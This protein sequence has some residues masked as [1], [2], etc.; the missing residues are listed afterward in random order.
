MTG[1]GIELRQLSAGMGGWKMGG[2]INAIL[3]VG[4]E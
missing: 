3:I 2:M 1:R 4:F